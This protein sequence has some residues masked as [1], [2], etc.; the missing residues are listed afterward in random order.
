MVSKM[1]KA[2]TFPHALL[3]AIIIAIGAV[4]GVV[5][6]VGVGFSPHNTVCSVLNST[7][8]APGIANSSTTSSTVYFTIVDS[9]PG[10][11]Y[12]G[13][14]GSAYHISAPWPV[15]QVHEGQNVVIRVYNCASSES[16]GFAITHYFNSGTAIRPGQ[17]FTFTF[18]ATQTGTFR[19]YCNIFCAIHP[20]MQNGELI[21]TPT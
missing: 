17:E 11:N 4:V 20:L 2:Q 19:I 7:Q 16:H 1:M 21:V 5:A 8:S 14:N 12:E 9:D 3:I 13:M 15:I 6:I 18:T 10:S